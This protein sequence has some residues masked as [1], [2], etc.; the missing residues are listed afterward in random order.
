MSN[1]VRT[2]LLNLTFGGQGI[3]NNMITDG[4]I[5][6]ADISDNT[7]TQ[8]K[9]NANAIAYLKDVSTNSINSGHIMAGSLDI[10]NI[11]GATIAYLKDVSQNYI[12]SGHIVDGSILG[13]DISSATISASNIANWANLQQG[14]IITDGTGTLVV[15]SRDGTTIALSRDQGT[16]TASVRIYRY[17]NL[18]G[19][20]ISSAG[21]LFGNFAETR[22][23]E[24]LAISDNGDRVFVGAP[25]EG[26]DEPGRI[27][28]Y[29]V[30]G[31]TWTGNF[32]ISGANGVEF[33]SR[34]A[35]DQ[36]GTKLAVNTLTTGTNF[37]QNTS[38][39]T[40]VLRT[41]NNIA[42]RTFSGLSMSGDG[43]RVAIGSI[44]TDTS[45]G[46]V[47]MLALSNDSNMTITSQGS[48]AIGD[49]SVVG[50]FG[51][52]VAINGEG[53][54][55]AIATGTKNASPFPPT[56]GT[57][58]PTGG[59]Y[60]EVYKY[61]GTAW[62]AYGAPII[63]TGT[64]ANQ[65]LGKSLAISSNGNRILVGGGSEATT[66]GKIKIFNYLAIRNVW[67]QS[68]ETTGDNIGRT[69]ALAVAGDLVA[70]GFNAGIRFYDYSTRPGISYSQLDLGGSLMDYDLNPDARIQLSNIQDV[71]GSSF[72]SYLTSLSNVAIGEASTSQ[73]GV[74]STG[75]QSFAGD[76]TFVDSVTITG[77]ADNNFVLDIS[78]LANVDTAIGNMSAN[79]PIN[80]IEL[81][82]YTTGSVYKKF[83]LTPQNTNIDTL[84]VIRQKLEGLTQASFYAEVTAIGNRPIT[85]TSTTTD[86]SFVEGTETASTCKFFIAC[87]GVD[88]TA[89][90]LGKTNVP[91]L[92]GSRLHATGT[93]NEAYMLVG[94]GCVETLQYIV[95]LYM[96]KADASVDVFLVN[97]NDNSNPVETILL[98]LAP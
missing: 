27:Y 32:L 41:F 42:G 9:I 93:E 45:I 6:D 4:S 53:N 17:Y 75:T 25:P 79:K 86:V 38:G 71:S 87:T 78:G 56:T 92:I 3:G 69:V 34:L 10:S 31:S 90:L 68:I 13:T 19:W 49:G 40:W 5:T 35:T 88:V 64:E 57:M 72:S 73:S 89:T 83:I 37:Y 21:P 58:G 2:Q 55:V 33:P 16:I 22:F 14:G 52:I 8:R 15:M 47:E 96:L 26:V 1:T 97:I 28:V 50:P 11:N 30:A 18:S 51:S 67:R 65:N 77:L 7:I 98:G 95:D 70:T 46:Q 54:I 74:V 44:I 24:S 76:K 20:T 36:T 94:I 39:T 63:A 23:G 29:D 43:T 84:L 80:K 48:I 66:V 81:T 82:S 91:P 85:F 61:N 60:I 62:I 59:G 12:N